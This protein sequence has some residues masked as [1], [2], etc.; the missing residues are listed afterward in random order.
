VLAAGAILVKAVGIALLLRIAWTD[1]ETQKIKNRDVFALALLGVAGLALSA[2]L[3]G[4]W[5]SLTVGLIAGAVLLV[6]MLPLWL[7]RKIG[8]GDVKLL[9]VAPLLAGGDYLFAFA[10]LLLFFAVLTAIVVKN[11][12]LLPASAFRRYIEVLDRKGVVPFGVP[13]SAS[14]IGVL[15]LQS[16]GTPL[17]A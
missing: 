10:L 16:L 6:A 2:T 13:I 3:S 7:L 1:F 11:P 12:L 4:S 9:A 17:L 14:L 5:S 8:A 15:V